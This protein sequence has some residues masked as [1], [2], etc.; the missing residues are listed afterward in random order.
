MGLAGVGRGR[1]GAGPSTGLQGVGPQ[2]Q[3]ESDSG[4]V[5]RDKSIR[6]LLDLIRRPGNQSD[7]LTLGRKLQRRL[8]GDPIRGHEGPE[9]L[10]QLKGGGGAKSYEEGREL[11]VIRGGGRGRIAPTTVW[12]QYRGFSGGSKEEKGI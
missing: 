2:G 9:V 1:G 11:G 7:K 12:A 10:E 5:T 6:C 3:V 4:S 8:K